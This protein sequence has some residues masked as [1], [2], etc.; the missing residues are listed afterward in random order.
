M[1]D[2]CLLSEEAFDDVKP[3]E[4]N[5]SL[6]RSINAQISGPS[7]GIDSAG[8]FHAAHIGLIGV[9]RKKGKKRAGG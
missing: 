1:I 3:P 8:S 7:Q 4:Q 6:L 5:V 9:R 2:G